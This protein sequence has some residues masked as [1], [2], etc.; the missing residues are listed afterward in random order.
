M[1]KIVQLS[2]ALLI[3]HCKG[4]LET[5]TDSCDQ[6]LRQDEHDHDK[7]ELYVEGEHDAKDYQDDADRFESHHYVG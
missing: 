4:V 7:R 3:C 6:D 2:L 5:G 1:A